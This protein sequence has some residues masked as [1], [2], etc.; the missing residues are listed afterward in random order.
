MNRP[1]LWPAVVVVMLVSGVVWVFAG[2]GPKEAVATA[3]EDPGPTGT[4]TEN[5]AAPV[6]SVS[7]PWAKKADD[8]TPIVKFIKANPSPAGKEILK[9][10]HEQK[11]A[12]V[13]GT[14][15]ELDP[16]APLRVWVQ[17]CGDYCK[18][19]G[20]VI[21]VDPRDPQEA[22]LLRFLK[23]DELEPPVLASIAASGELD[24]R[25]PSPITQKQVIELFSKVTGSCGVTCEPGVC[26]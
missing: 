5:P 1:W 22:A 15:A 26:N 18:S 7:A 19:L 16:K 13:F 10:L 24:R 20:T 12:V 17:Q 4:V 9:A 3:K 8:T 21:V 6:T 25:L 2:K 11:A 23:V 14:P